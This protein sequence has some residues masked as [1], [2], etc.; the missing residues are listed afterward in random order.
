MPSPYRE[1]HDGYLNSLPDRRG[2]AA[3]LASAAWWWAERKDGSTFRWSLRSARCGRTSG[4]FF[5]GFVR[6]LTEP[7]EDRGPGCRNCKPSWCR[8]SRLTAMGEMASTLA[9]ELNQP[10]SGI[11]NY[12][13]RLRGDCSK[14]P[15]KPNWS[16][17]RE[18]RGEERAS[19]VAR[20]PDHPTSA[21]FRGARRNRAA[22]REPE[23][24]SS[25]RQARSPWLGQRAR[26]AGAPFSSTRVSTSCS[27]TACRSSR[28]C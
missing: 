26:R 19:G 12:L 22:H 10:L 27:P 3:S 2:S 23:Q 11:T 21:R 4:D 18:A 14:A 24:K 7:S 16:R 28:C 17:V 13:Q 5:T 20:R 9:H 8:I 6:D 15:P 25:K 1:N